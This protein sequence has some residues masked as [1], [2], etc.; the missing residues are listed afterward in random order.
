V[1]ENPHAETL[2]HR[3]LLRHLALHRQ[4]LTLAKVDAGKLN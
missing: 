2:G 1:S 4:R 3:D